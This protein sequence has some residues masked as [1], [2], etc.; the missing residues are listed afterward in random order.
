MATNKKP[1]VSIGNW[2]SGPAISVRDFLDELDGIAARARAEIEAHQVG[3]DPSP[4][5]R[6]E[7]RRRVL[8]DGDFQFFAY[9]YFP[10]HVRGVPSQFQQHFCTRFPQ[11]LSLAGGATEWWVAPRGE[12]K[13]TLATKIGPTYICV[14]GLLQRQ[15]VRQEL[16]WPQDKPVPAF[17]DYGLLLG[18]ETKLPTKLLEVIKTEL[19]F[20]AALALDFPEACGKGPVWK[21]GE[22]VSRTG[23][24]FEPFGAEQ[25]VRGTF[26]G[27]AR[28][29]VLFGDDLITDV[30]AKSATMRNDR[31]DWLNKAIDYLGPPD[32]SVK[33]IGVG[34][35]L[36]K[37]DPISHAKRTPGHVV[38]HFR[39]IV[40]FPT[41]MDLWE[42]CQELMLNADLQAQQEASMR[43]VVLPDA[44]L[45]SA[46]FYALWRE[47]MN[48]GAVVSWP[49]VRS[50]YW[51]MRQRTK[52]KK[53]FDTEMQGDPRTDEDK[54]FAPVA[55]WVHRGGDWVM[56]GSCDPSMGRNESADPSAI[57]GGG[58]KKSTGVLHVVYAA[59]KRRVPSKIEADL[60]GFQR[61]Q[62][63]QA[64]AFENN[65]AFEHSR[66]TYVTNSI[67]A[68]V[69]L[70]LVGYTNP[71]NLPQEVRIDGLEP[72]ITDRMTPRIV[73]SQGLTQLLDELDTWP[74]KK[75][76]H[77]Y[78]GL[79]ALWLLWWVATSGVAEAPAITSRQPSNR[80]R[81][82]MR[83]Y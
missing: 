28:P 8:V 35:V 71:S 67:N 5:A 49:E 26:H 43:G 48:L 54:V 69:P 15:E 44:D 46:L 59:I 4:A 50:L 41:R 51:L 18:A 60:I 74:E 27:S 64:I 19:T 36:N 24:K 57:L 76:N 23:V 45:P 56:F 55:F 11:I 13:S 6:L 77:H 3:L 1:S 72:F 47:E 73:F 68:G 16:G 61:D 63:C 10:H 42:K 38:H 81:V 17:M 33:F 30:E 12:C 32:G 62:K 31:W 21:V 80:Y 66:Q 2:A 22:F 58:M 82:N 37:D 7:R 20:N 52:A 53:A 65:G 40:Q 70:P 14:Q 9:T 25:A 34:T 78:D 83:G 29:K 79:C 39:A 75:T